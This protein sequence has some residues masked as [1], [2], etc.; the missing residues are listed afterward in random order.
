MIGRALIRLVLPALLALAP[1]APAGAATVAE[2]AAQARADLLAAIA[3]MESAGS[4]RDQVAALTRTIQAYEGGL[5][6]LRESLRQVTIRETA[7]QLR[8]EAKRDRVA[9]L[10]GVL[11]AMG[12]DP[13]PLLLLHPTGPLGTARSGMMLAEL[14]PALQAEVDTLRAELAEV[15]ALRAVAAAA[16]ET[17]G[18]GLVTAQAA[19]TALSQALA[20]RTALPQRFIGDPARLDQLIRDAE[21][22][23]VLAAGLPPD[24]EAD[25]GMADFA[26]AQ[27][28]LDL[29][30]LGRVL[31]RAGEA[32]AAGIVRP[33]LVLATGPRALVTAPW[34]GTIRYRGRFLD[35]GNVMILEPGAGYLLVMAGLDAVF[36]E[37]GEV[38]AA[39]A[40]LGLMGDRGAAG[41]TGTQDDTGAS[42][43]ETLYLELRQGGQPV[44]PGEWFAATKE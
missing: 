32:D 43:P 38:V 11:G 15:Q 36:G 1:L 25:T 16:T 44:D 12:G 37:V 22:L 27:G 35:Y 34:S 39:G 17:L 8:F 2:T 14:T 18:Q 6:A 5:G 19:R 7:L 29:P 13:S 21:T 9:R 10:V 30:V 4:G 26:A 20:A 24:L 23:D 3:G 31:R 42:G 28:R 40:P 41:R 33:G